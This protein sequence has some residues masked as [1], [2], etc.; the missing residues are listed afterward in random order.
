M[1]EL[2]A[3]EVEQ[4]IHQVIDEVRDGK[5]GRFYGAVDVKHALDVAINLSLTIDPEVRMRAEEFVPQIVRI[6][7]FSALHPINLN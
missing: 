6:T 3:I 4:F 1:S 2:T 5:E 7:T